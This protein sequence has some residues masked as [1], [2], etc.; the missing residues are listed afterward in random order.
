M[1]FFVILCHAIWTLDV[2]DLGLLGSMID[3]MEAGQNQLCISAAHLLKTFKPLHG[4]ASRYISLKTDAASESMADSVSF[5]AIYG[6]MAPDMTLDMFPMQWSSHSALMSLDQ[7][8][9]FPMGGDPSGSAG[10][11]HSYDDGSSSHY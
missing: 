4:A 3:S 9:P 10:M 7:M 8:V 11:Q 5:Q 1:P 6:E 2:S